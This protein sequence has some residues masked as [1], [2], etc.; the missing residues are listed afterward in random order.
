VRCISVLRTARYPRRWLAA[1]QARIHDPGMN[2]LLLPALVQAITVTPA[3]PAPTQPV[4]VSFRAPVTVGDGS[5]W[6]EAEVRS[7][8]RH[9]DCEYYEDTVATLARKGRRVV[10]TMR[11]V[12]KGRWCA[13][14]YTG[15]VFLNRRVRC[16]DRIDENTCFDNRRIG[17]VR[18][19]VAEP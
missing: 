16:E 6:Y 1:G 13:G 5:R 18:F 12:D 8:Q 4:T 17:D 19:T 2:P 14:A 9:S 3:Q 15:T 7:P 10:L 11:P